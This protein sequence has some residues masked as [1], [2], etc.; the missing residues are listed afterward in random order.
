MRA[1]AGGATALGSSLGTLALSAAVVILP[2]SK[3][4]QELEK[5]VDTYI[6]VQRELHRVQLV[7]GGTTSEAT[8]WAKAARDTGVSMATLERSIMQVERQLINLR[9]RQLEG[10]DTSTNFS[11]ALDAL[12]VQWQETDG[13]MRS[14]DAVMR[15]IVT[16]FQELGPSAQSSALAFQLFGRYN[17]DILPLL[18]ESTR[19]L[20][21]TE[22]AARVL[23][24]FTIPKT[25]EAYKQWRLVTSDLNDAKR[26]LAATI[27][28]NVIPAILPLIPIVTELIKGLR[29]LF[30]LTSAGAQFGALI[31]SG[32]SAAEAYKNVRQYVDE[33]RGEMSDAEK[34]AEDLGASQRAAAFDAL[35]QAQALEETT[36]QL[37]DLEKEYTETLLD[38][39]RRFTRRWEDLDIQRTRSAIERG[40][41]LGWELEDLALRLERRRIDLARDYQRRLAD[42]DRDREKKREE[43]EED[44]RD[45]RE[46]LEKEHLRR[47]RDIELDYRDSLE[48]AVRKNDAV[49]V[50]RAMR[51]RRRNIR[52]ENLRYADSQEDLDDALEKRKK[53]LR[54]DYE[55]RKRDERRRYEEQLEDARR[56]YDRSL[57]DLRRSKERERELRRLTY[58]WEEEDLRRS[59]QRME[60]DARIH[61]VREQTELKAHLKE[62]ERIAQESVQST[63]LTVASA[64]SKAIRTVGQAAITE[65]EAWSRRFLLYSAEGWSGRGGQGRSGRPRYGIIGGRATGGIDVVNRPTV[66]VFGEAGP[67]AMV[68]IPLAAGSMSV[69]HKFSPLP[70]DASG[71]P[72]NVNP[73][74]I[75]NIV[76]QAMTHMAEQLWSEGG[77]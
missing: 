56:A 14:A 12:N 7:M 21:E 16:R 13:T 26:G 74:M 30:I 59:Q 54:D 37:R 22:E 73:Q 58:R 8:A 38:I 76:Y 41:R 25:A 62:Q 53:T 52:D 70:I 27:G 24:V 63:G 69:N 48:E 67:E 23:G 2:L 50:L 5:S 64:T 36:D 9:L 68:S 28:G 72:A 57:E 19:S 77:G 49:A 65:A 33:A 1:A 15:D 29:T 75:A 6:D 60:E 34:A 32:Q 71:I 44:G 35:L 61:Y 20:E 45:R 10:K 18:F 55:E 66:G 42:I 39:Q 51:E 17:K 11:R 3:I 46:E 47:L 31:I 43:I 40:I 4:R